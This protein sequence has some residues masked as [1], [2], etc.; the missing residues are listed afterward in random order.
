M[1]RRSRRIPFIFNRY[2]YIR[3]RADTCGPVITR[4]RT[5]RSAAV[6]L[7]KCWFLPTPLHLIFR[8]NT[9]AHVE[10]FKCPPSLCNVNSREPNIIIARLARQ[11]RGSE[12]RKVS[13]HAKCTGIAAPDKRALLSAVFGF[14]FGIYPA[15]P[16]ENEEASRRS[17][18]PRIRRIDLTRAVIP[19]SLLKW[20]NSRIDGNTSVAITTLLSRL[21][22]RL[23]A[24][25]KPVYHLAS[26]SGHPALYEQRYVNAGH[27]ANNGGENPRGLTL[28]RSNV[29][30]VISR[31]E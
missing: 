11:R 10:G 4:E 28:S 13:A 16:S 26:G 7:F 3:V 6:I 24:A 12:G 27:P 23:L 8:A 20:L 1:S 19:R 9:R 25:R 14:C 15:A 30:P 5:S 29:R 2:A 18:R 17:A 31:A 21:L 22:S